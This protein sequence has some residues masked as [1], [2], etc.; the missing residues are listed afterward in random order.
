M[1]I[2]NLYYSSFNGIIIIAFSHAKL[3][4]SAL[5]PFP[6]A[7]QAGGLGVSNTGILKIY[8]IKGAIQSNQTPEF[9]YLENT[10]IKIILF[11]FLQ[12]FDEAETDLFV[13]NTMTT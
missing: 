3:N 5:S 9:R 7:Q 10:N 2:V 11:C 8:R 12:K 1:V 6:V 4:L 13:R